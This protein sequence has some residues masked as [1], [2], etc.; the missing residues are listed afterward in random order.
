VD[1]EHIDRA[2]RACPL[3]MRSLSLVALIIVSDE[4]VTG[5]KPKGIGSILLSGYR[6]A[7]FGRALIRAY[8]FE[9]RAGGSVAIAALGP[10]VRPKGPRKS[11][12]SPDPS[13]R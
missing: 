10:T 5:Y 3:H 2:A 6:Y 8:R 7:R 4:H 11:S 1:V 9:E 12:Y 13:D